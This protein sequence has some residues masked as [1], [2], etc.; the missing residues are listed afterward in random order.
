MKNMNIFYTL[1]YTQGDIQ[2]Y[3]HTIHIPIQIYL[4]PPK[5]AEKFTLIQAIRKR[6]STE[7][8]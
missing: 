6:A 8:F 4:I 5:K 2:T 1:T 7:F 3:V